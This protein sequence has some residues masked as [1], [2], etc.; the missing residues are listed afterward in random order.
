MP[1]V[2]NL[3]SRLVGYKDRGGGQYLA[4]CP[5]HDDR[6]ESLSITVDTDRKILVHCHAG[7]T[8]EAVLAAVGLQKKHLFPERP[9]AQIVATYDYCD[10]D[11]TLVYQAVRM[12][13]K[14]FRH[15][16]PDGTNGWLWD[17]K[18]VDPLPYRLQRA[19]AAIKNGEILFIAE[20]E[21]DVENLNILG[22]SA[23]CNSG[24]AGKWTGK[25]SRHFSGGLFCILPDNDAPGRSHAH[26]TARALIEAG[27]AVKVLELP[28][29]PDKGDVSDWI[30]AGG[31]AAELLKLAYSA[32]EYSEWQSVNGEQ[33][34]IQ[35]R[36]ITPE[37]VFDEE[38]LG[39]LAIMRDKDP[40][41]YARLKAELRGQIN[42]NDLER[43]VKATKEKNRKL[44]LV[45]ETDRPGT[46]DEM[47]PALP[48]KLTQPPDYNV[49]PGGI[50]Y[51]K[52]KQ[53]EDQRIC[54]V[55]VLLT[56]RLR[57]IDTGTERVTLGYF[58]DGSWHNITANRST[59][60]VHTNI[61]QLEDKG[62]PVSSVYA[63]DTV[64]YLRALETAN[65]DALPLKKS[66]THLGWI[67][68]TEFY[69][70][71]ETDVVLDL[72]DNTANIARHYKESGTLE[73]WIELVK[74][75][76]EFPLARLILAAGFASPL[77][78]VLKQR[79][80]V[81]YVWGPSGGGKTAATKAAL[82]VW[83][84]PEGIISSF[85]STAVG[86]ERMAGL[87]SDLPLGIDERQM[88]SDQRALERAIYTLTNGKGKARGT[89]SG[90]LQSFA[91]WN[92]IILMN[93]E[94]PITTN[95][96]SQ[97]ITT[98][99]I[100]LYGKV[101]SDDDFASSLH[102]RLDS[103][104]G[105]AGPEFIKRVIAT[106]KDTPTEIREEYEALYDQLRAAHPDNVGQHVGY[107]ATL[108][109][110]DYYASRW[111]FGASDEDA[112]EQA[113]SMASYALDLADSLSDRD[114]ANRGK[115]FLLS[116]YHMNSAAFAD[117]R[118]TQVRYGYS[119]QGE[120][121]IYPNAFDDAMRKGGFNPDRLLRDWADR[122]WIEVFVESNG[123]R[124]FSLSRYDPGLTRTARF[125]IF[126]DDNLTT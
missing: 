71:T 78:E 5:A 110:A 117:S 26:Q 100:E 21:K 82:S 11:G 22:L 126:K 20:G 30:A 88:A 116:W 74:P 68:D 89:K 113:G 35:R 98:R 41:T 75:L 4:R 37:N 10:A 118:D 70:G 101:I 57:N 94:H 86:F 123:K 15:R 107:V 104:Y 27:N 12:E 2:T 59:V 96:S 60:F 93:G 44:K 50:Y 125:I 3:L 23:T 67:S 90:G 108:A 14:S 8:T 42:L 103:T 39:A 72:E 34:D 99:T 61:T 83:G 106:K 92:S 6:K 33:K 28:G 51:F 73:E 25:H 97:G 64:R 84:N 16:R 95:S 114:E 63:K 69:P 112:T 1:H 32:P 80:F 13:P 53:E 111:L 9:R 124:R 55:P 65:L 85:N 79:V 120:I 81:L 48:V 76:R 46:L 45:T 91:S 52:A 56:E 7:C 19:L 47:L 62:L 36:E 102:R 43:A 29:L 17:M 87:Y 121:W 38:I 54:S 58:R 105:T 115:E 31:T 119:K 109:I 49:T 40:G 77:L 18:G 66:V 122:G 24:G